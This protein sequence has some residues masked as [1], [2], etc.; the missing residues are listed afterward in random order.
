MRFLLAIKGSTVPI[1]A[2]QGALG[3]IYQFLISRNLDTKKSSLKSVNVYARY[4]GGKNN[5]GAPGWALVAP[6]HALALSK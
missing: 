3:F 4:P 6:N 2:W 5:F 1:A